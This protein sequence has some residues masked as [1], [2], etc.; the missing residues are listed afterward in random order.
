M[1]YYAKP[2]ELV[3][4]TQQQKLRLHAHIWRPGGLIQVES[5]AAGGSRVLDL[6][7]YSTDCLALTILYCFNF[8]AIESLAICII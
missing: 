4:D 3:D 6:A 5:G 1:S 2:N 7:C 8:Q